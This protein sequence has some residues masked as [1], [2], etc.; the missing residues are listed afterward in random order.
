MKLAAVIMLLGLAVCL[1]GCGGPPAPADASRLTVATAIAP[2]G[3]FIGRIGGDLVSVTVLVP[4]GQAAETWQVLPRQMDALGRAG[5]YF[6]IGMPF[7]ETFGGKIA[8]ANPGIAVVDLR[9]GIPLLDMA[10]G[11]DH[12]GDDHDHGHAHG[13]ADPHI[14]MDPLHVKTMNAAVERTL[15]R[16]LPEGA[17]EFA[18]NRAALDAELDAAHARAAAALAPHAGRAVHVFHPAY[19]Y[20]CARYGLEQR[21]IEQ[22]GKSPG[23]RRLNELAE[24]MKAGGVRVIFTQPQFAQ[25]EAAVLAR[26]T[27]ARL[28]TLND[29]EPD[30]L[31]NF[32]RMVRVIAESFQ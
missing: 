10:C 26:A 16:L 27:G 18:A 9:E 19:G 28:V 4:E 5:A 11:H 8:S 15:A 6:L 32:D 24:E 20:F 29:L 21:A 7:E 22:E 12:E 13:G 1:A 23:A 31:G 2:V 25:G 14:W 3:G 17:A 30:Y